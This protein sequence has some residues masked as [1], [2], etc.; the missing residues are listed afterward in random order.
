MVRSRLD[1]S[2]D[3]ADRLLDDDEEVFV[4]GDCLRQKDVTKG[5]T[6]TGR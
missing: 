5:D 4:E 2:G 6:V 3:Q 1:I